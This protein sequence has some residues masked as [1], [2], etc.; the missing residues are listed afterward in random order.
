LPDPAVSK[1]AFESTE[2]HQ[3]ARHMVQAYMSKFDRLTF[4]RRK[5]MIELQDVAIKALP[6]SS[7]HG[8][9]NIAWA[10]STISGSAI[11]FGEMD[12]MA[13]TAS[14]SVEEFKPQN[15]ANT[16][17]AF[18]YKSMQHLSSP[19]F[20]SM[21]QQ[22]SLVPTDFQPQELVQFF[23]AFAS[24]NH[25]PLDDFFDSLNSFVQKESFMSTSLFKNLS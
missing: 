17:D 21:S 19:L 5:E 22:A 12:L 24:I 10:L 13:K 20:F 8:I 9:S 23:W 2:L 25:H 3:I 7:V 18:V 11:Y 15:L 4:A 16:A 14:D 6:E 1:I